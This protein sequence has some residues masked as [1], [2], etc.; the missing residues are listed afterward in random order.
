VNTGLVG[1]AEHRHRLYRPRRRAGQRGFPLV[2]IRQDNLRLRRI[3][4]MGGMDEKR[5]R[6]RG[7]KRCEDE[8]A[9]SGG[10]LR[11]V[12]VRSSRERAGEVLEV[13][14]KRVHVPCSV[15]LAT[16]VTWRMIKVA[17]PR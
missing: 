7:E 15:F 4:R 8:S 5:G 12:A 9:A 3:D 16:W 1:R 10:E 11:E 2:L 17:P 6:Q 13:R 14:C